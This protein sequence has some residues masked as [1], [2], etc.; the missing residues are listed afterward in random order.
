MSLVDAAKEMWGKDW[1]TVLPPFAPIAGWTA[2]IDGSS[3]GIPD[4]PYYLIQQGKINTSPSGEKISVIMGTNHD[5]MAL[6][7]IGMPVTINGVKLPL[8]KGGIETVVYHLVSYHNNWNDTTAADILAQFPSS[9]FNTEAERFVELGTD[10]VFRCGTRNSVQALSKAGV[11]AYLYSFEYH[12]K[13][14]KDPSSSKCELEDEVGCGCYHSS[15]LKYVFGFQDLPDFSP[16]DHAMSSTIQKYWGNLAKYGNPNGPADAAHAD[17]VEVQWPK[18]AVES[19]KH[20][21]LAN[22]VV[23]S[24]GLAKEAC[25]FLTKLPSEGSYPH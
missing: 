17:A 3:K 8:K 21:I 13:S 24:Y 10:F 23:P 14:Y 18:Y 22:P 11:D 1:P 19:D 5:E 7:L 2:V 15:E 25:D 6:F 4:D 12:S 16:A 20:L 9:N